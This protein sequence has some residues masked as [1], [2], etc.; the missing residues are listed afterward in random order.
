MRRGL[1]IE[2]QTE[3]LDSLRKIRLAGAVKEIGE[4][5]EKHRIA[6]IKE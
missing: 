6:Q 4:E 2:V 5:Y 1:K 3:E